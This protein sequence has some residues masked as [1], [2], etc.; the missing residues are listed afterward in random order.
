MQSVD[1]FMYFADFCQNWQE[2]SQ[3]S[4]SYNGCSWKHLQ[5]SYLQVVSVLA[6]TVVFRTSVQW[7]QS[8]LARNSSDNEYRT[9]ENRHTVRL[10]NEKR[11]QAH[12]ILISAFSLP[13]TAWYHSQTIMSIP[14]ND[15]VRKI[16]RRFLP[17]MFALN[18]LKIRH[19]AHWRAARV[20][21]W[22]L[23][24][25]FG[26][27]IM[28]GCMWADDDRSRL[29]STT[30]DA[31]DKATAKAINLGWFPLENSFVPTEQRLRK[32]RKYK[33]MK[34]LWLKK[35]LAT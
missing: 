15:K 4:P 17:A 9:V 6:F 1:K 27:D 26:C 23:T 29:C 31:I 8:I 25:I 5:F 7:A 20:W 28:L 24:K 2:L 14:N 22:V 16:D 19:Y 13:P 12:H 18:C 11:R 3:Q 21:M 30:S 33:Y 34:G 35:E 10:N 32:C